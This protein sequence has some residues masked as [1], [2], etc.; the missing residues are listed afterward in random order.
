[1]TCPFSYHH[2]SYVSTSQA[3]PRTNIPSTHI[4]STGTQFVP[5]RPLFSLADLQL[6]QLHPYF[7]LVLLDVVLVVLS[8]TR[9]GGEMHPSNATSSH[10]VA[11]T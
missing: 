9:G 1:M 8:I 6:F 4:D 5:T 3:N 10:L 11:P 2:T 7:D